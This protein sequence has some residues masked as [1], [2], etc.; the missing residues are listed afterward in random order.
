[1]H[2]D[3]FVVSAVLLLTVASIAVALFKHLGL[4]SVLGL[5]VAGIVVGPYSPGPHITQHVEDVRHFTELG[6][7]M[8]LFLIGLELRPKR[9]W[10]MRREVFG[11]GSLQ[12]ILSGLLIGIYIR[13]YQSD[14]PTAILIGLTLALSSTAF[15]LQLLQERGE[16]A[17][18]HG[19][20]TFAVLLM[21]DLA[22]VPLLALVPLI[23]GAGDMGELV[24]A[25][26]ERLLQPLAMLGLLW[27]MGRY[28][29]PFAFERLMR[30]G[31]RE[32]FVLLTLLA[33]F[34]AAWSMAQ[35]GVSMALGAFLMGML[36]SGSRYNY[37]IQAHIEPYKG[38]LMSMFFIA[39]GM[40]INF[41]ALAADPWL[42]LQ[43]TVVI[44]AIKLGVLFLLGLAFGFT[45]GMAWRLSCWLAQSGEFGFV[46]FGSAKALGVVDDP[47]FVV[48]LGVISL[49]M[50]SMPLL[51]RLG[52]T[53]GKRWDHQPEAPAAEWTKARKGQFKGRVI[54][55]G[56]G[57]VGHTVATMLHTSGIGLIAFDTDPAKVAQGKADGLP[58]YYGDISDPQLLTAAQL[59]EAALVVLTIDDQAAALRAVSHIRNVYPQIQVIARAGDLRAAGDLTAAGVS[60]AYP[61]AIE[62]SLRLGGITLQMVGVAGDDVDA[63]LQGVR[64]QSYAPV[65]EGGGN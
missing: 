18:R 54:I 4:G 3:S 2:L 61:E 41:Q 55:G 1:M 12:I 10:S 28:A 43:H 42:F 51:V 26:H 11:L 7:V 29:L 9:L 58:V 64:D 60:Y 31:N 35:A 16:I 48:G 44:V 62:S 36:L 47:T 49:S 14:W 19:R 52:D 39:V 6:V 24:P 37:Q 45:R 34:F 20:T 65:L 46:L 8:L 23:G 40:S 59:Q 30:T 27:L 57:R 17:S 22:I 50:L 21:Q 56:Y 38:L 63:L 13:F 33:V 32:G 25:W 5:L 15:V 53:L